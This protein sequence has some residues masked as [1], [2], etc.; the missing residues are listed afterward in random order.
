M[1]GEE[2]VEV[3]ASFTAFQHDNHSLAL[4]AEADR[5]QFD[6]TCLPSEQ[7]KCPHLPPSSNNN[8]VM[9]AAPRLAFDV[10]TLKT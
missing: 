1:I 6:D 9:V 7:D 3:H 10:P 4:A 2:V 8:I 5:Q